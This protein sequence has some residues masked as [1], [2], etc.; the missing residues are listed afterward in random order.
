MGYLSAVEM[1]EHAPSEDAAL[2]WH[3]FSNHFPPLP[4][5]ILPVA[6]RVLR[7]I[8]AGRTTAKVRLPDGVLYRGQTHAPVL[9]CAEAWHLDAFLT[10]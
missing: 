8:R 2:R 9:V 5:G 3:L 1:R 7:L 6:K 10:E 4:S